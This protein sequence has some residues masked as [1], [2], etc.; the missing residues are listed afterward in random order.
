MLG[1]HLSCAGLTS[2]VNG[3]CAVGV[4]RRVDGGRWF[5]GAGGFGGG[6]GGEEVERCGDEEEGGG[7]EGEEGCG[8]AECF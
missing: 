1:E 6:A 2:V 7:A 8:G 5:G 3:E 4:L